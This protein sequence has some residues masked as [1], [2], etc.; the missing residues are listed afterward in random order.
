MR[1]ATGPEVAGYKVDL[2]SSAEEGLEKARAQRYGLFI[3]DVEM[4]GMNGF[5]FTEV[6]R[7]DSALKAIPVMLVTSLASPEHRRRGITAGASAY[8]VKSEFDQKLFLD[9]VARFLQVS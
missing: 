1:T 5:E 3:V 6:T 4:P 7:G 8:I 2:A 9:H